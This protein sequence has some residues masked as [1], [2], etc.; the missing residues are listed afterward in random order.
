MKPAASARVRTSAPGT[1]AATVTKTGRASPLSFC[2]KA[3]GKAAVPIA[4]PNASITE[5]S[6]RYVSSTEK[7]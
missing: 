6:V 5:Q 3:A 4:E 2:R 1:P 7:Q